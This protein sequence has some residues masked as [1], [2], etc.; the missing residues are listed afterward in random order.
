MSNLAFV[1]NEIKTVNFHGHELPLVT[2]ND[3]PHVAMKPVAEAIGLQWQ[4]QYNRIRRH[5]VLA[6]CVSVMDMQ[7]PGDTQRRAVVILPLQ[8]LN[9]WLFGI[10][11]SRVKPEIRERLVQ[12]QR[13][14]FQALYDY[15]HQGVAINPRIPLTPEH[16]RDLQELVAA[17]VAE[18]PEQAR[19]SAYPK[20]WGAV[21]SKFRVGSYKDLPD[22][23]YEEARALI[24]RLPLEGEWLG[25]E[26]P[27]PFEQRVADPEYV[28]AA[29]AFAIDFFDRCR[30]A[31]RT[32][33]PMPAWNYEAEQKIADAICLET[34]RSKRWL[35]SFSHDGAGLQMTPV[36]VDAMVLSV[37]AKQQ[38]IDLMREYTPREFLPDLL[39]I[40]LE[41]LTYAATRTTAKA[42]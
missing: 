18:L 36:P 16:Q 27:K 33:G 29:R 40:G 25:R 4:S 9:G 12:Y 14:C 11:A 23:Q 38:F 42:A 5:P 24:E 7:L 19:A 30:E 20:L 39:K 15:W 21:K 31:A 32:S 35:V 28:A 13:E 3:E 2:H 41:R 37:S 17:R 6:T 8:Y 22:S 34:L 26:E 1:H 10:D